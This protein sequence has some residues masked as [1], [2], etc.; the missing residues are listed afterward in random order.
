MR[1]RHGG[2]TPFAAFVGRGRSGRSDVA[3]SYK[4]RLAEGWG[5][6]HQSGEPGRIHA[7]H[8]P[9]APWPPAV[10]KTTHASSSKGRAQ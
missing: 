10:K 6:K 3:G 7:V 2:L 8:E 9:V 1:A 5:A 4:A